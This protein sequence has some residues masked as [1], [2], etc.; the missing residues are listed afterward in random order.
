MTSGR[1]PV[2][3]SCQDAGVVFDD[4]TKPVDMDTQINEAFTLF[5]A[6]IQRLAGLTSKSATVTVGSG[7][8]RLIAPASGIL[9]VVV[10]SDTATAGSTGA[11]Y[12]TFTLKRN[13][14]V[15][16]TL[17]FDTRRGELPAYLGGGYIGEATVATGDVITVSLAV[18]GAPAPTLTTANLCLSCTLRSN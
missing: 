10:V 16:N 1:D 18:T 17:S 6:D 11:A 13:G 5:K 12:H 7:T 9:R 14:V 4:E 15:A 3:V 8:H 2:G